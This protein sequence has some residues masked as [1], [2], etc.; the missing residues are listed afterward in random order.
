MIDASI[1]Q[2]APDVL[3]VGIPLDEAGQAQTMTRKA[4]HFSH[5]LRQRYSLPVMEVDERFSSREAESE[6]VL[7]R[8]S[9]GKSRRLHKGDTD[10]LAAAILVQQWLDSP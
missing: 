7:A 3:L 1:R 2:W 4:R 6:L 5:Q 8:G 9:G 10:S